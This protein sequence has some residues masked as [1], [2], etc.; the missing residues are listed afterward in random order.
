MSC[1]ARKTVLS[2]AF[3]NF[4]EPVHVIQFKTSFDGHVFVTTKGKQY[5]CTVE[6]APYQKVPKPPARKNPLEGTIDQGTR[7]MLA[8]CSLTPSTDVRQL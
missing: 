1:S 8:L 3:L 2:R 4:S 6:Y 5:R 7:P